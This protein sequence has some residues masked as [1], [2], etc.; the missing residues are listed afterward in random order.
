M[1]RGA[2]V[3]AHHHRSG[4]VPGP[5]E[6]NTAAARSAA[7]AA[8]PVPGAPRWTRSRLRRAP[9][10]ERAGPSG[11]RT[12]RA[13]SRG[14]SNLV[15][16]GQRPPATDCR[17]DVLPPDGATGAGHEVERGD[18]GSRRSRLPP[19]VAHQLVSL[20]KRAMVRPGRGSRSP[21]RRAAS[22]AL[23]QL[24]DRAYDDGVPARELAE[25]LGI[26]RGSVLTQ[27]RHH[28]YLGGPSPSMRRLVGAAGPSP[29]ASRPPPTSARLEAAATRSTNAREDLLRA[30]D[31]WT[32]CAARSSPS[33]PPA[34][35]PSPRS[36][37][38]PGSPCGRCISGSSLRTWLARRRSATRGPSADCRSRAAVHRP[39][40]VTPHFVSLV[41]RARRAGRPA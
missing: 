14:H 24:V 30:R 22:A 38:R 8:V 37:R 32:R 34:G 15:R 10:S 16:C 5:G 40:S 7:P 13:M 20:R 9:L 36:P 41:A 21:E 11:G 17:G 28:G 12:M 27:L 19:A 1:G 35:S 29:G 23:W 25:V 31:A 18:R 3:V 26:A 4:A 6:R 2:V 33:T 39:T